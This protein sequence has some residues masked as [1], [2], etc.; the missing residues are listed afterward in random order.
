VTVFAEQ[1]AV[2]PGQGGAVRMP[3]VWVLRTPEPT[4]RGRMKY[5]LATYEYDC[6]TSRLRLVRI[7]TYNANGDVLEPDLG[8]T[9]FQEAQPASINETMLRTACAPFAAWPQLGAQRISGEGRSAV[10]LVIYADIE[11]ENSAANPH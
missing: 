11:F 5:F 2:G 9:G 3:S 10:E 6:A 8:G 7:A 4:P 1:S